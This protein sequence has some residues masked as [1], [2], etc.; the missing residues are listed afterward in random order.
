MNIVLNEPEIPINTGNIGRTCVAVG[1]ALHLIRPLG[2]LTDDKSIKRS[3]L[4]YWHQLDVRYYDSFDDFLIENG[5]PWVHMATTKAVR[6]YADV[7]YGENAFIM[8]GKESAGIP[9]EIRERYPDAC[10]R[11]PMQKGQRSLNLANAVAIV[12]YEALRQRGFVGLA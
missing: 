4:D 1:A 2:F 6:S 3:G 10:M 12:L 8:F 5:Q 11:I 9:R 7:S